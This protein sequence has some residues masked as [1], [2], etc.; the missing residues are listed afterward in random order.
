VCS[1]MDV[2]ELEQELA[3]GDDMQQHWRDVMAKLNSPAIKGPDKLRLGLLYAL[4]Y[5][6]SANLHM[7]L[8]A[9]NKA[10]VPPNLVD[11]IQAMLRYAGVDA[12]G[13]GLYGVGASHHLNPLEKMTK[14]IM[15]SV[16][17]CD[18]VYAQHV[19]VLM[20]TIEAVRRGKLSRQTH[21]VVPGSMNAAAAGSSRKQNSQH[22]QQ[23]EYIPDEIL[24]FMVGGV[25]YEE[26]TKVTEFNLQQQQHQQQQ[27]QSPGL[28][29]HQCR[30]I[31]AGSTVH[32]STSFLDELKATSLQS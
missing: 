30:V 27:Q 6:K 28:A 11:L 13:P 8:S 1:L 19:P 5:E 15:T 32:N 17:G 29:G 18:N 20:D 26:G 22:Q 16:Q 21:P 31:L 3:C 12:R 2:S 7:L 4:R 10:G 23:P 25:T 14:S 9:M 24:V